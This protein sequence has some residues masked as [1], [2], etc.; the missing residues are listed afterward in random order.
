M[1]TRSLRALVSLCCWFGLAAM[2]EAQSPDL[3]VVR[4][5]APKN[6]ATLLETLTWDEA[7]RVLTPD[8]VVAIPLGAGSKEHGRHLQLNNDFLMA[9]YFKQRVLAAAPRNVIVAPTINYG[10]Y[11]AFLEY[12][13]STSLSLE[14][15]R[16]MITDIV[17]SLAHYGPH[18][19][20]ILNTGIS[21]LRPL[22]LATA[23][24]VK[25][26]ILLRY[27]DLTK[28][29][30]VEK[31]LR[32]SGG[33][34][35]DEMETS[36]MLYIAPDSVGMN[37]AVRDLNPN[38]PG[39]LTRDPKG[40][41]TY[42]P[43]G[44]WGDPTLA[45]REKGQA[46]VESLVAAILK[47]IDDLHRA[48]LVAPTNSSAEQTRDTARATP[49]KLGPEMERL[50]FLLGTWEAAD[51]YEKTAFNPNGGEGSGVYTTVLGPGGFS[52]LTDYHYQAPHGE[53]SGHQVLTWDPKQARYAGYTVASNFAGAVVV[54]GNWEGST[55]VLSGEFE[56]RGT[57]VA[58]KSIFSDIADRTM[59]LRQYNSIDG[60]PFQLFGTTHFTRK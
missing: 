23:D 41:G 18:R 22:A 43:T 44:A 27:L 47:D 7:E 37:K 60:A 2:V 6:V 45:T 30:P 9:E 1:N 17:R 16:A 25:D 59:V 58:F 4:Q 52:V 15:A 21:T 49:P 36:M 12:P 5:S 56:A 31:K 32:Q 50:T 13:G 8:A 28:D 3:P 48:A 42:S 19:F 34:H 35:A 55:L 40:K 20:Y 26:G 29:N 57:K 39:G 10:F 51:K 24:L 11:P 38:Q 14:T 54:T 33:T 46:M 53:S